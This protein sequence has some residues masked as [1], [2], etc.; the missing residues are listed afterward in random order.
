M[1]ALA[2]VALT[3]SKYWYCYY[4]IPL[5]QGVMLGCFRWESENITPCLCGELYWINGN[6]FQILAGAPGWDSYVFLWVYFFLGGGDIIVHGKSSA[7]ARRGKVRGQKDS[8]DSG[9][10]AKFNIFNP[11]IPNTMWMD[12]LQIFPPARES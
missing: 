7:L 4:I 10:R 11:T 5:V 1:G 12:T 2:V 6:W 8:S 3:Y 9:F